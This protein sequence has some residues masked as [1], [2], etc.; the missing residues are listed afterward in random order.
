MI[1]LHFSTFIIYIYICQKELLIIQILIPQL[2]LLFQFLFYFIL[3][4]GYNTTFDVSYCL[5]A[6]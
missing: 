5:E 4:L 2:L 3:Y 6:C 1:V